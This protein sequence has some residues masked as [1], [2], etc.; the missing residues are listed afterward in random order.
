MIE[1]FNSGITW[2]FPFSVIV[3]L[4]FFGLAIFFAKKLYHYI[5]SNKESS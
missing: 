3:F 5:F 4:V 2:R 1:S